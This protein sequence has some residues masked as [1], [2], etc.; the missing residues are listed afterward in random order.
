[1][2]FLNLFFTIL[3]IL[4]SSNV[5]AISILWL[6]QTENHLPSLFR[7]IQQR[8]DRIV[9]ALAWGNDSVSTTLPRFSKSTWSQ[10]RNRLFS[11][12][13]RLEK[14]INARFDY[15]IFCDDDLELKTLKNVRDPIEEFIRFLDQTR[16]AVS[17]TRFRQKQWAKQNVT[18]IC[19]FD[20]IMNA[21]H[22]DTL[23]VLLP[24]ADVEHFDAQS[25]WVSQMILERKACAIYGGNIFRSNIVEAYNQQ[26]RTYPRVYG[27]YFSRE[28]FVEMILK[29]IPIHLRQCINENLSG[30]A[31]NFRIESVMQDNL[32]PCP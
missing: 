19:S 27:Q 2:L 16:P 3:I 24:Y 30:F 31:N 11:M 32:I 8:K 7:R 5:L 17:V 15:F 25:W 20:A 29:S 4:F 22:R 14:K 6:T 9:L 26:H 21:F 12:G 28:S 13:L 23:S 18:S 10:G 1:M